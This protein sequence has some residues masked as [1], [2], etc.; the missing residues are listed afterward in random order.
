MCKNIVP[1]RN[2]HNNQHLDQTFG[3]AI[4]TLAPFTLPNASATGSA[5]AVAKEGARGGWL[6]YYHS[7]N[8]PWGARVCSKNWP[9]YVTRGKDG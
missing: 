4:T 7:A 3:D 8:P 1:R 5:T 9:V 2:N 6:T